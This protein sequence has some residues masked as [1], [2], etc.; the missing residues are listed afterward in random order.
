MFS[1]SSGSLFGGPRSV[2]SSTSSS[3]QLSSNNSSSAGFNYL[4][5][6]KNGCG[7]SPNV[8]GSAQMSA[9]ALL[10]KA[11]QMGATA[12]NTT[13]NSPMM[14]KSFVTSM[15]GPENHHY[16]P[17]AQST[18]LDSRT[19]TTTTSSKSNNSTTPAA[20]SPPDGGDAWVHQP[21]IR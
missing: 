9:T 3:L 15:A 17:L 20:R 10:Q 5:D 19:I 12:S 13:I 4:Q 2:N 11:A 1:T 8:T 6:S 16:S 18:S 21:A 7:G 14:Q